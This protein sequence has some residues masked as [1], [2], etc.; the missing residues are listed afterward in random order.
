MLILTLIIT[1]IICALIIKVFCKLTTGI[2]TCNNQ[3]VS[4]V[5]IVTKVD[6]EIG[7]ETAKNLAERGARVIVASSNEDRGTAARDEIIAST[8]NRDVHYRELDFTSLRSVRAFAD[9]VIRDEKRLDVLI[10][11]GSVCDTNYSKTE[12]GLLLGMQINYFGPF[13]LTSLLLPLL[14]ASA[15]SRIINMSTIAHRTGNIDL[16]NLNMEGE[17][18]QTFNYKQAYRNAKLCN[19]LTTVELAQILK[20]TGVTVNSANPGASPSDVFPVLEMSWLCFLKPIVKFFFKTSWEGAQT[21]IYLAVSPEVD[22]VSGKHFADCHKA[23]VSNISQD[24]RLTQ[25]LWD[26]SERLVGLK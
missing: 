3:L 11:N 4:K 17:T 23:N 8:G 5:V 12:D 19:V 13:L 20:G 2:C 25:K 24:R 7:Y 10:N 22:D 26:V 18:E 1:N 21:F 6:E 15:P 9:G 14:K 16:D